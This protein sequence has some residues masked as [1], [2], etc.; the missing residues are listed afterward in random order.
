MHSLEWDPGKRKM[1][2]IVVDSNTLMAELVSM[3]LDR[4]GYLSPVAEASN[5]SD[6]LKM[7]RKFRPGLVISS[8][9]LPMMN[10]AEMLRRIR[11]EF[12]IAKVILYS[13]SSNV[14]LAYQAMDFRPD[15]FIHTTERLEILQGA[16]EAVIRGVSFQSPHFFGLSHRRSASDKPFNG[17]TARELS[18]L[19]LVAEGMSSK[20]IAGMLS[21]SPKSIENYRSNIMKRLKLDSTAA[22]TCYAV[23]CGLIS[24]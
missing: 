10:G 4:L 13:G 2:V 12:P 24:V 17:L 18:V 23:K 9:E 3:M 11:A 22:L 1:S 6:G 19:Q 20:Q 5:G 15:G 16:I 8:L 14:Q 7:F 21:L